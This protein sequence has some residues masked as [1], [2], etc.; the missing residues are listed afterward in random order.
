[1]AQ[2][3]DVGPTYDF[4]KPI[5]EDVKDR[6]GILCEGV[7]NLWVL[8]GLTGYHLRHQRARPRRMS[9]PILGA[10]LFLKWFA[11]ASAGTSRLLSPSPEPSTKY[12]PAKGGPLWILIR[13][14]WRIRAFPDCVQGRNA[15]CGSNNPR[16]THCSRTPGIGI[17]TI[18]STF[19]RKGLSMYMVSNKTPS[20]YIA[21]V[22][23]HILK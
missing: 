8:T 1:M 4:F 6:K 13:A 5:A 22:A 19:G 20:L 12:R 23:R 21:R 14:M 15:V 3:A 2:P 9:M 10:A 16:V 17:V 18:P 7:R 11:R